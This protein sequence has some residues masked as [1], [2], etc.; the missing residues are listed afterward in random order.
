VHANFADYSIKALCGHVMAKVVASKDPIVD[1]EGYEKVGKSCKVVLHSDF[2]CK[3][4]FSRDWNIY[5]ESLYGLKSDVIITSRSQP[6]SLSHTYT[7]SL[8]LSTTS[9]SL[10]LLPSFAS[11][12]P[13]L[14]YAHTTG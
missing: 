4:K 10:L 6:L 7:I 3:E 11:T 8:S 2:F 14:F 9:T 1:E 13:P 12:P 5:F